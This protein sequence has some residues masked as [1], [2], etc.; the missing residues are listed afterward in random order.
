MGEN[1]IADTITRVAEFQCGQPISGYQEGN[2]VV[3]ISGTVHKTAPVTIRT[4]SNEPSTATEDRFKKAA[5]I[6]LRGKRFRGEME[7]CNQHRFARFLPT[8]EEMLSKQ[9]WV[10]QTESRFPRFQDG[11]LMKT[12]GILICKAQP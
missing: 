6:E 11:C 5:E 3:L 1:K 8:A 7:G 4:V 9:M 10:T 12:D 2:K